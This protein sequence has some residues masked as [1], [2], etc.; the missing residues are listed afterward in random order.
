M[1]EYRDIPSRDLIPDPKNR[2][3]DQGIEELACSIR[4][5][6]LLENVVVRE[7]LGFFRIVAGERRW[8]AIRRLEERGEWSGPVHCLVVGNPT[9]SETT[10]VQI[11]EN[12][13]R[14]EPTPWH[15]GHRY[16]EL[17]EAGFTQTEIATRIGKAKSTVSRLCQ[18]AAGLAPSVVRKLDRL[19]PTAL[20]QGELMSIASIGDEVTGEPDE[21]GQLQKL[22]QIL[23]P[24]ARRRQA[25]A[26][27]RLPIKRRVYEAY[28]R[29]KR[30]QVKIPR[31]MRPMVDRIVAY[32]EG[33]VSK[34]TEEEEET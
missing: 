5:Y 27:S 34:L 25:R 15:L 28:Y 33:S 18:I 22:E 14:R 24:G 11:V 23:T 20:T 31:K 2:H 17:C 4:E 1:S 19:G 32:L 26:P 13:Q 29:L 7:E 8:K 10:F 6:G 30:G 16:N 9:E 21:R 3:E 12:V